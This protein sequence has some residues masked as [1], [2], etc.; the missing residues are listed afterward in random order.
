MRS[1]IIT[2]FLFALVGC[3][4]VRQ[5]ENYLTKILKFDARYAFRGGF[6]LLLGHGFTML[7]VLATSYF[8][9]NVNGKLSNIRS[10]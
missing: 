7:A 10:F 9:A 5:I 3:T 2:A 1:L 4:G 6:W 8:F